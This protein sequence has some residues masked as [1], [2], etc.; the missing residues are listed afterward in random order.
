MVFPTTQGVRFLGY[1]VWPAHRGLVPEN[2][3]RFQRRLRHWQS[4]Y[5]R[6]EMDLDEICQRLQS[7]I[8]HAQQADT[9]KLRR[10]LF[11]EHVF[12]RAAAE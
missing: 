1:R 3:R 6:R 7:W 11:S 4:C 9:W 5:A 2:V 8:G 12:R 10:R